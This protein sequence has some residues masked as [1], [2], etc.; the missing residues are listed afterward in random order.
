MIHLLN[1]IPSQADEVS[2]FVFNA[3]ERNAVI[4]TIVMLSVALVTVFSKWQIDTRASKKELAQQR[5]QFIEEIA[6]HRVA[7]AKIVADFNQRLDSKDHQV[8]E[9]ALEMKDVVN[10]FKKGS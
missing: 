2:T 8:M 6:E 9:F 1:F 5:K 10:N 7:N 3:F 4:A